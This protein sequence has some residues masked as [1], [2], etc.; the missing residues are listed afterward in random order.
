MLV[1]FIIFILVLFGLIALFLFCQKCFGLITCGAAPEEGGGG[2]DEAAVGAATV[3]GWE[4]GEG[5][6]LAGPPA[7]SIILTPTHKSY[8]PRRLSHGQP[9]TCLPA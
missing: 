3:G 4:E 8:L 1:S 5:G 7:A 9:S 6:A 2:V